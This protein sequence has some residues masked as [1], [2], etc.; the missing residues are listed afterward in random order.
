MLENVPY[1]FYIWNHILAPAIAALFETKRQR[2]RRAPS[3]P[4]QGSQASVTLARETRQG[5]SG[6]AVRMTPGA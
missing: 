5:L 2:P 1:L 6:V 3:P 4:H